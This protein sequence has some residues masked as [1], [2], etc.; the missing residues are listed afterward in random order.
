MVTQEQL[1]TWRDDPVTR[2]YIKAVNAAAQKELSL[3]YTDLTRAP[4]DVG[5][6]AVARGNYAR[7]MQ[8]ALDFETVFLS[9]EGGSE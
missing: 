2:L 5:I 7:G 9:L 4:M 1:E 3:E 8:G 6:E